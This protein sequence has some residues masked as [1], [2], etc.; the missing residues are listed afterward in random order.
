[1]ERPREGGGVQKRDFSRENMAVNIEERTLEEFKGREK[2][3][4]RKRKIKRV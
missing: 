2:A 1:M 3:R 4:Q